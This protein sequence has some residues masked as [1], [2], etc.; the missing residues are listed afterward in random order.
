MKV[1]PA[2]CGRDRRRG[3]CIAR[4]RACRLVA[5]KA[6]GASGFKDRR[7]H[8]AQRR[9]SIPR[10]GGPVMDAS[11]LV[12]GVVQ[13]KLDALR[14]ARVTGDI[15]QNVNFAVSLD[16]LA[17]FLMKNKIVF[18]DGTA[19]SPLNT[20]RL[21][22]LAQSFTYRVECRGRSKQAGMTPGTKPK[23]SVTEPAASVFKDCDDCPEMIAIPAGNFLM[24]SKI[25]PFA[26]P[27]SKANEQ[28]QHSVVVVAFSLGKFEVTQEQWYAV[29]G[30]VP[31]QFRGRTLPVEN[32]S[33][34][35]VQ[36][37]V[38]RLSVK[39]GK[40]YRL[41]SEAEWENAARA[42][43]QSAYSFGDS[44]EELT[45]Y[46]WFSMNSGGRTHA[47]GGKLP[48]AFGLHD[49]H[50]NVWEWTQDCWNE[51]YIGA[52]TNG[53]AWTSGICSRPVARGGSWDFAPQ[54]LRTAYRESNP[55]MAPGSGLGFRVAT[56]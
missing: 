21:A 34:I 1:G 43:S 36:E 44:S 8:R 20:A 7:R 25:D 37:F 16:V 29:M 28:P 32:V 14:S 39:T 17:A 46:A 55:S 50:G 5:L 48:N 2:G 10:S 54:F 35:D 26:D 9:T 51:N 30:N 4:T 40:L 47:V 52:P 22:E 12:I 31:S 56:D 18:R 11:G 33:W 42:G 19:A 49:M 13:S 38:R 3:A 45:R 53:G 41:P 15:P 23:P 24:G 27:P 6:P